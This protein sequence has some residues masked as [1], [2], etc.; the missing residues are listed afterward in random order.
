MPPSSPP[1]FVEVKYG[2]PRETIV[3]H[4]GRKYGHETA[5]TRSASRL[6]LVVDQRSPD[7]LR[8][9][10]TEVRR[11]IRAGLTVELWD[12]ARLLSLL[13]EQFDLA[14]ESFT[15]KDVLEVRTAV[16]R[17][18]GLY[19][20]G[21][22]YNGDQLQSALLWHFGFWKLK[23]LREARGLSAREIFPPGLYRGVAV[24]FA[25]LS[26]FSSFVRDTRDDAVI[27]QVLSAFYSKA[28]Y[29]VLNCGGMLYQF[30]GDGVIG[31]FGVPDSR[32]GCA[33]DALD[34]AKGLIDIGNS[35]SLEWQRSIDQLQSSG[36]AH[37]GMALGEVNV[38]S[39]RPYG[40]VH[41]GI[42]AESVNLSAR[43]TA[44]AEAGDIVVS[45]T[46]YRSLP[47]EAQS[48][49]EEMAPVEARNIGRIRAWRLKEREG[50]PPG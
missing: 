9:I 28:R 38:M 27:R 19:A 17:T 24:L 14:I 48:A 6:V 13:R 21:D 7:E 11:G 50:N 32:N 30:L 34:C 12:E 33:Q 45:N 42:I 36:G 46:F 18:K 39:L 22:Q 29:Q 1:Y 40:R 10:E 31:L 25:D 26:S 5:I 44:A 35:V 23:Q 4:L 3:A 2:Y 49:F 37:I 15:S 16:D 47:E 20:F 43:L 8:A 41:M